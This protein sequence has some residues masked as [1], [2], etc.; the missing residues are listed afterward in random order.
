MVT[1]FQRPA[2]TIALVEPGAPLWAQRMALKM[3]G[4]FKLV[5]P[6]EPA[7]M[8][9]SNK[10]DLPPPADWK[11]C[12]VVVPDQACMAVS[13]GLAWRKIAFGGPV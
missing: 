10:V 3:L 4:F 1:V 8:W 11:G 9:Q 7:E 2:S 12:I 13:D 5:H 6:L